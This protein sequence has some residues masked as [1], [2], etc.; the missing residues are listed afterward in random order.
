PYYLRPNAVPWASVAPTI[1]MQGKRPRIVLGSP[2]SE[3]I[4]GAIAQ[5]LVRLERQSLMDA[6]TA[7]RLHSSIDGKVTLE[8]SRMRTDIPEALKRRGFTIN[9]VEPF[10]FY[11]GCV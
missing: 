11:L 9:E 5:V 2:G 8:A 7:P 6:I 3:R 1:V 4:V 10:S